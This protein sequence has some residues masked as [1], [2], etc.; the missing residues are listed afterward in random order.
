MLGY[1]DKVKF[2][3][4]HIY[5]LKIIGL[6]EKFPKYNEGNLTL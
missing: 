1:R 5:I 6:S 4:T 2:T 3:I